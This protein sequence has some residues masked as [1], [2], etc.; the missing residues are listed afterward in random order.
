[1]RLRWKAPEYRFHQKGL[2]WYWLTIIATIVLMALAIWQGNFLFV[3]FIIVAELLILFWGYK[4]PDVVEFTIDDKG[5]SIGE[6]TF[7]SYNDL[8]GFAISGDELILKKKSKVSPYIKIIIP[9]KNA[10]R[11]R[12]FLERTLPEIEYEESLVEHIGHF[13]RF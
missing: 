10:K 2:S 5:F 6:N 3:V 12:A 4:K 1:M 9:E 13:V 8:E 7:Y 11:I